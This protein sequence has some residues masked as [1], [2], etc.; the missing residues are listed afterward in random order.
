MTDREVPER[1][2]RLRWPVIIVGA[3]AVYGAITLVGL[4]LSVAFSLT[5]LLVLAGIVVVLALFF[6]GPPDGTP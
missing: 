1:T 5:K 2:R 3:L 4:V 6:R